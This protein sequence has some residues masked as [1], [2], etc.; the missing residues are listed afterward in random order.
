MY[1]AKLP[2]VP[3]FSLLAVTLFSIAVLNIISIKGKDESPLRKEFLINGDGFIIVYSTTNHHSFEMVESYEKEIRGSRDDKK[4]TPYR[5][6]LVGNKSDRILDKQVTKEEG[7]NL[8]LKY[9]WG[10][11]EASAAENIGISEVFFGL[12]GE[13]SSPLAEVL[14]SSSDSDNASLS[15]KRTSKKARRRTGRERKMKCRSF[16]IF[17]WHSQ[18]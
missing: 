18:P 8:A 2:Y 1:I 15:E 12:A 9:G 10:F 7:Q 5:V 16:N 3:L 4:S 17:R 13:H 6:N 11:C 14:A